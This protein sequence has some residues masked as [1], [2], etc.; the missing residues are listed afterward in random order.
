LISNGDENLTE[1][2]KTSN[3]SKKILS[4]QTLGAKIQ[5]Q[6]GNSPD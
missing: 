2:I 6:E 4:R 3:T 5:S 1:F